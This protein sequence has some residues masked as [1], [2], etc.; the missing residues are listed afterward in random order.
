MFNIGM[1][2]LLILFAVAVV[3]V[4]PQ[5]LPRVMRWLAQTLKRIRNM[6][7]EFSSALNIE[8]EIK[9]VKEAGAMLKESVREINPVA[10][11]T[12]EIEKVRGLTQADIKSL[13]DLPGSLNA[14]KND[15]RA[16]RKITDFVDRH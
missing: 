14:E 3:V 12:D 13:T 4:G 1:V 2:E 11:L 6:I 9:E 10:E 7:Q 16:V 8:E 15:T 5:D